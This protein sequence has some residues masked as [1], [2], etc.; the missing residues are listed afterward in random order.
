MVTRADETITWV[1]ACRDAGFDHLTT[2]Q[3][4]LL[5]PL[6]E[7]QPVPLLARLIPESGSMRLAATVIGPLYNPVDLAETWA[8]LDVLTGGRV[9]LCLA[10]GYRDVEYAAFGVNKETRVRDLHDVVTT[11][12]ELWRGQPVTRQGR[13]FTLDGA[14]CTIRPL[15]KPHPPIWIA[16]GA[17]R[18]VAR[19]ARW[20]L[21]W[22]IGA[23][24]R[25][26]EVERKISLYRDAATG[27]ARATF[28][29]S[30]ELFCAPTREQAH[31]I[32]APYL[33]ERYAVRDQWRGESSFSGHD[34][35]DLLSVGHNRF[36][37]GDPDDCAHE[38]Q[39]Y[40]AL[41]VDRLHFRM[42]WPGMPLRQAL[43][44][45]TLF[46]TEVLPRF[47]SAVTPRMG[48]LE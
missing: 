10:L 41:G 39:R 38:I 1:R 37:I 5:D 22:N 42:N 2:G 9:T 48:E 29:M 26:D 35:A 43:S 13:T 31:R 14:V 20:G 28:P 4:Y 18:A 46:A 21:P 32:A 24:A 19:A 47:Q 11:L 45:M 25:I 44:C 27:G 40:A 33:L 12:R 3:H 16:A 7:L 23:A 36:I 30:R 15:Q 8:S 6:Q 17:D 34:A